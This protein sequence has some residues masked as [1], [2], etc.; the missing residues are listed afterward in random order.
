M[1]KKE[2]NKSKNL[3]KVSLEKEKAELSDNTSKVGKV[4]DDAEVK[5]IKAAKPTAKEVYRKGN[6]TIAIQY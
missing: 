3:D 6:G 1:S 5:K 2:D 4:T